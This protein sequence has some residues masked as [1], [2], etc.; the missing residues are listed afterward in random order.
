MW[1]M[2]DPAEEKMRGALYKRKKAAVEEAFRAQDPSGEG[3]ITQ[4]GFEAALSSLVI[5]LGKDTTRHIWHL[6]STEG[7]LAPGRLPVPQKKIQGTVL[8]CKHTQTS[9]CLY[10]TQVLEVPK[11]Q[12]RIRAWVFSSIPVK[13]EASFSAHVPSKKDYNL[14]L[15]PWKER[16]R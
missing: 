3:L 4:Q 1:L 13:S 14:F 8:A 15:G 7:M 6:Y 2:E 9:K 12:R 5:N 11:Y 10:S 16:Q